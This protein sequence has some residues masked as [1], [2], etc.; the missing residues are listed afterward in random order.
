MDPYEY[1]NKLNKFGE[2]GGFNPGLERIN[3]IL[4]QFAHP[5]NKLKVIHVAGSN[6]KGSTI[7]FLRSVYTQAGYNVGAYISPPLYKFNE[8][9]T[10]NNIPINTEE[11]AK[12]VHDIDLAIKQLKK[13]SKIL[14][15][16]FFEFVTAIAYLYFYRKEVDIAIMEVGLGG[17]L[18]ATNIVKSPLISVITS[19]SLEHSAILGD[20]IAKIAREKAGI[21][22]ESRPVITGIKQ[23]ELLK[24]LE[25]IADRKNASIMNV[26]K[27]YKYKVISSSLKGQKVL[28]KGNNTVRNITIPL[29]GR[30]QI[31][32]ALLALGV[33]DKLKDLFPVRENDL[34]TGI[35]STIWPGRLEIVNK[36]P[37]VIIDGA[38]NSDGIK[39]LAKFMDENFLPGQRIFVILGIL[40]DKNVREML[41]CLNIKKFN[42][43]F[44]ITMNKNKRA[45]QPAKIKKVAE[46]IH[47]K[48]KIFK[49]LQDAINNIIK[50][51][52]QDDVILITG[53]LY[54]VREAKI[55]LQTDII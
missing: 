38:H 16:S 37:V 34:K 32:N 13:E 20:T 21:I 46:E 49:C 52:R 33:I 25:N 17:R 10:I 44:I 2:E 42:I 51:A 54:T 41:T 35:A 26:D 12:I 11:L 48:S 39:M 29:L 27:K 43:E 23:H 31:K 15:P 14:Q 22:K 5:E 40:N 19:I 24:V 55:I 50:N 7:A 47:I 6:G 36:N 9:I 8:R 30:H 4:E 28:I 3:L 1:I 18:D 53:S 45:L